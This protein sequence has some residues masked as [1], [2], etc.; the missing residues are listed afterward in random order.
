VHD[1]RRLFVPILWPRNLKMTHCKKLPIT[2]F[3]LNILQEVINILSSFVSKNLTGVFNG[4][5]KFDKTYVI[6]QSQGV[7]IRMD[8]VFRRRHFDPIRIVTFQSVRSKLDCKKFGPV[9]LTNI[10]GKINLELITRRHIVQLSKSILDLTRF[11][12]RKIYYYWFVQ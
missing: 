9:R 2:Q 4:H 11:L 12:R 6:F 7:V 10:Q 8:Y 3:G 5:A 1:Y